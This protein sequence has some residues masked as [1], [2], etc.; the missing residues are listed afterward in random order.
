MMNP[1]VGVVMGSSS[2]WDTMQH[3]VQVLQ[4]FGVAHEAR[5]VVARK[6]IDPTSAEGKEQVRAYLIESI[7]RVLAEIDSFHRTIDAAKRLN[8]PSAVFAER[9][10]LYRDRGLS[11]DTSIFP[12]FALDMTLDQ[13]RAKG[14]LGPGSVK[15]V[16]IVGPGLDFTD[17]G[18]GYDFYPQQTIQ[19]FA[20][21]DSLIRLGLARPDALTV[22][23]YDLSP[24]INQHLAAARDRAK[25]GTPYVVQLPRDTE[26]NWDP[27]LVKYWER[28]G[29]RVGEE[30]KTNAAPGSIESVRLRSIRMRPAVVLSIT[31]QDLNIVLQRPAVLAPADRYDLV[32][33]TNILVYYDVFEQS[34]ALINVSKLLRP[35][36][37]L[38]SNN[39]LLEL[40]TTPMR[41]VG[42]TTAVYSDRPD[43]GDHIVWYQRQP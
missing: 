26:T 20:V 27:A 9:S 10:T 16:A 30:V 7:G 2:D 40:P 11:S 31:P 41:S 13:I 18:E 21:M 37:F 23:T 25:A 38:L 3:A 8:D 15:R 6:G 5:E 12:D 42:Y 43:D 4:R 35:G 39:A 14:L 19:P 24:R 22:T 28:F 33:A 36:G 1:V 32:I 17:K 34:L 29:D